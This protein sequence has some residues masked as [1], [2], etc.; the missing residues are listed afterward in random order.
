MADRTD[1]DLDIYADH[2]FPT[3]TVTASA[4][5]VAGRR[6]SV[7]STS[8]SVTM[9]LPT[10]AATADGSMFVFYKTVAGNSMIIDGAGAETIEGSANVTVTARYTT[11]TIRKAGAIWQLVKATTN[12]DGIAGAQL[13]DDSVDS[14]HIAAGAVD[15]EHMSA[16]SVDSDQYVDGSIDPIHMAAVSVAPAANAACAILNTTTEVLLTVTDA[17]NT[18]ISTTSSVAG[19][20]VLIRAAAVAGGGSYTLAVTTGTLTINSVGETA[21]VQRN[22]ANSAWFVAALTAGDAGGAAA[23]VV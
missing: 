20:R 3:Y 5:A 6:Y 15:L 2:R 19:Q 13:A 14:E 11:V 23:T 12:P 17:T 4:T 21:L 10:L 9:T 7:D 18:A 8:G 1:A 16:N 22:V